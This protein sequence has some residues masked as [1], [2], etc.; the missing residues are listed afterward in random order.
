MN[1]VVDTGM[2]SLYTDLAITRA[3][4]LM[5]HTTHVKECVNMLQARCMIHHS[6]GPVNIQIGPPYIQKVDLPVAP[7]NDKMYLSQT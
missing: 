5:Y 7:L 4:Q 1:V 6:L 2:G 3:Y